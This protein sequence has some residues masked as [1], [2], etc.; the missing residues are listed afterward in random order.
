MTK[1]LLRPA[2]VEM[3]FNAAQ[4]TG[5]GGWLVLGKMAE[6]LESVQFLNRR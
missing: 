4:L 1:L 6:R 2:K 3:V 5:F